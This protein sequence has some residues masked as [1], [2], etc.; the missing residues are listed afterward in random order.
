MVKTDETFGQQILTK[1]KNFSPTKLFS[2]KESKENSPKKQET[3]KSPIKHEVKNTAL[4]PFIPDR[5]SPNK[6][7][8]KRQ[9]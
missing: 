3:V 7:P 9:N 8:V 6:S 2:K 1:L 5:P 4:T